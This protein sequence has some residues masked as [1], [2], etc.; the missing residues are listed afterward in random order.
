[1]LDQIAV[2]QTIPIPNA[3]PPTA[4]TTKGAGIEIAGKAKRTLDQTKQSTSNQ[5]TKVQMPLSMQGPF[6]DSDTSRNAM[7]QFLVK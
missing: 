1:M 6:A 7:S 2:D 4:A 5:R 3:K